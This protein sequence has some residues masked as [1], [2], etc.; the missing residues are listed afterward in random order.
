MVI[1]FRK[2][3]SKVC[4]HCMSK[5]KTD[6]VWSMFK[7]KLLQRPHERGW[8]DKIKMILTVV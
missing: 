1:D 7:V 6:E 2:I 5:E 8:K 4:L 3:Y